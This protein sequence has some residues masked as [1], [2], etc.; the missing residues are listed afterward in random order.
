VDDFSGFAGV[1]ACE[2]THENKLKGQT[3]ANGK[4]HTG[5]TLPQPASR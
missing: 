3:A 1:T 2:V 4:H 5:G